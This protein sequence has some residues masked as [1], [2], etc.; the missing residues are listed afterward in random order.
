MIACSLP[1]SC[2]DEIQPVLW[3]RQ[4]SVEDDHPHVAFG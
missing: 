1:V 2:M 4:K 3:G